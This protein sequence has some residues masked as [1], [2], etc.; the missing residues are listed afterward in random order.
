[1]KITKRKLRKLI[2]HYRMHSD[3]TEKI[4][5]E[6]EMQR[7]ENPAAAGEEEFE[8]V[9]IVPP[10][11]GLKKKQGE[12]ARCNEEE[13]VYN[14]L[15]SDLIRFIKASYEPGVSLNQQKRI[16]NKIEKKSFQ[17]IELLDRIEKIECHPSTKLKNI[18]LTGRYHKFLSDGQGNDL[19][20]FL[21]FYL[22]DMGNQSQSI[23]SFGEGAAA[24]EDY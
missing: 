21:P 23:G 24:G 12:R 10:S 4:R 16:G 17:I 8:N 14:T 9:V 13:R 1:M 11:P 19:R 22:D 20:Y 3:E 18:Q 7:R 6:Y 2:E 5:R 15:L